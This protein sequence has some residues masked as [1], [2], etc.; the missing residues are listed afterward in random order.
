MAQIANSSN[1][2]RPTGRA[3]LKP[4]VISWLLQRVTAVFIAVVLFVHVWQIHFISEKKVTFDLVADRL[5]SPGWVAV[6]LV[7]LALLLYHALN[8][9]RSIILDFGI[10]H[11]MERFLYWGFILAGLSAWALGVLFLVPFLINR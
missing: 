9:V 3:A 8:G 6:D 1:G 10:S 4:G 5:R 2:A 11:T 7:L